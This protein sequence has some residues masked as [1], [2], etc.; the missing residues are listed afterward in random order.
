[1]TI[2][3]REAPKIWRK[4]KPVVVRLQPGSYQMLPPPAASGISRVTL[5][6]DF[7]CALGLGKI[8]CFASFLGMPLAA[9]LL[10]V[11]R[12]FYYL[13]RLK[14]DNRFERWFYLFCFV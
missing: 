5:A 13:S 6:A 9:K 2:R 3:L 7:G 11:A 10:N 4:G 1:M 14:P 8:A 12:H